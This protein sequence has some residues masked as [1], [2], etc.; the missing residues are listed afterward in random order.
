MRQQRTH[1]TYNIYPNEESL[2]KA[3]RN[4]E[5][6]AFISIF[7]SYYKDLCLYAL[8]ILNDENDAQDCVQSLFCH[9]WDIRQKLEIRISLKLYLYRSVYY[10]SISILRSKKSFVNIYEKQGL[11]D[12]YLSNIIQTPEAELRLI[13]RALKSPFSFSLK[14][15]IQPV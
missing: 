8:R 3:L 1:I 11:L 7:N 12:L 6:N 13:S 9:I 10:K 14:N 4:G 2:I 5:K 15:Y